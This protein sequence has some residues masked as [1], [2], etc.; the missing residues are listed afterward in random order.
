MLVHLVSGEQLRVG[1]I[2]SDSFANSIKALLYPKISEDGVMSDDAPAVIW[3]KDARQVSLVVDS[4][5]KTLLLWDQSSMPGQIRGTD[6]CF[7]LDS[8]FPK[9]TVV[10]AFVFR[11]KADLGRTDANTIKLGIFDISVC[12]G[13]HFHALS[14]Q[15]RHSRAQYYFGNAW[16]NMQKRAMVQLCKRLQSFSCTEAVQLGQKLM[17]EHG[18]DTWSA[19]FLNT[20]AQYM[21]LEGGDYRPIVQHMPEMNNVVHPIPAHIQ[22]FPVMT[23]RQCLD[24]QHCQPLQLPGGPAYGKVLQIPET[25]PGQ[26]GVCVDV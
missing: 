9:N 22:L 13:E 16:F 14:R 20:F 25:L 1:L 2:A 26:S 15:Q 8:I 12:D 17:Q 4:G 5:G 18:E 10:H 7:A 19:E 24:L 6:P 11:A 23:V 21:W 3:P